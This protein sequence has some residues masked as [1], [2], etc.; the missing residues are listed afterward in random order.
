MSFQFFRLAN[1]KKIFKF[2]FILLHCFLI[3]I[4]CP[5]LQAKEITQDTEEFLPSFRSGHNISL[6]LS[7]EYSNWAMTQTNA[8]K[9]ILG[10][11]AGFD[12]V[13]VDSANQTKLLGSLFFRYTY[14][15]NILAGFGFFVG[16]TVGLF[17]PNGNYGDKQNFYVG[18]G[19]S[20]PTVLGGL[21]QNI[22]QNFRLIGGIEYGAAWFP[23][24]SVTTRSGSE[25]LLA[26]VP[27]MLSIYVG[28][29]RFLKKN[30]ALTIHFGYRQIM[31]TCLDNCS[32]SLYLNNF[33]IT[34][35]NYFT[36]AGFTWMVGGLNTDL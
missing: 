11:Q 1:L 3:L 15:I 31:N 21:V 35:Q 17:S 36:Q 2:F 30:L 32:S 12:A 13:T 25:Q 20:F 4:V 26:P 8:P 22:G 29:D 18:Y 33:N 9:N 7:G 27:D 19:V 28:L 24:M 5:T 14:H 34:N 23:K 6:F 10:T 16:S